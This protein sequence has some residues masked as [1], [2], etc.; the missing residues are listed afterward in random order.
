MKWL[1]RL[2]EKSRHGPPG[3]LTKLTKAGCVSVEETSVSFVSPPPARNEVFARSREVS[4]AVM[5]S[6]RDEAIRVV[7]QV[8]WYDYDLR[9]GV[10]TP[11]QLQRARKVVKRGPVRHYLLRW[12]GGQHKTEGASHAT[13]V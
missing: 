6:P 2:R 1:D 7:Y 10:Y 3:A 13:R 5:I 12:Q 8:I 4:S 11:E 9:D